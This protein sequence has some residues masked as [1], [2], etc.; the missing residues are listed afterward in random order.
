MKTAQREL[1]EGQRERVELSIVV[2]AFEEEGNIEKLY[3]ELV[4]VLT[5]L[6]MSW[7]IVF[8]DDGSRDKT[9]QKIK[10]LHDR[11]QRVR[12]VRL[13]RNF[14]HQHA[15]LAGLS[16]A[17]G[18]AVVTM[19]ADLQHPP[20]LIVRLVEEWRK[21]SKIVKTVRVDTEETSRFKRLTSKIYYRV[22]TYL[23][24]VE[25][26]DGMADF[27]LLDRQVLEDIL[28]FKEEGLFLRGIVE[29]VG[30]TSSVV[31]Y[32][33][34][35]RFSGESRYTLRKMLKL[36]WNG[37]SSFSLV[38]LRLVVIIGFISSGIALL[39]VLYAIISKLLVEGTVSGW[40]SS[41]AIIS[42]LFGVL[43]FVLGVLGEYVGR[44]LVEVRER[45][46]FLISETLGVGSALEVSKPVSVEE[47]DI[48][49]K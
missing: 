27:R 18:D 46:R 43:F 15:L 24:G 13:S 19:D 6:D 12:G 14:G 28:E 31:A 1:Q 32:D 26:Q 30:Y 39:G 4:K 49:R 34:G 9:W 37:V 40:A 36:A 23:S 29:W 20:E 42:F 21:G 2:P 11:D 35:S 44:V 48:A 22:F 45:P 17:A 7:E 3:L 8:A 10:S 38:P 16:K 47:G 33:C 5:S 41:V 25:I